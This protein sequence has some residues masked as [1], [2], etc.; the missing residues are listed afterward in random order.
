MLVGEFGLKLPIPGQTARLLL[1]RLT[2]DD[3]NDLLEIVGDADL[4][5]DYD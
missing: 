2:L 4:V 3:A 1:R 5:R